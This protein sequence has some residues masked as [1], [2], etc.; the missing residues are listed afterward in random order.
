[1]RW[2]RAM[3]TFSCL[4]NNRC[5]KKPF[6]GERGNHVSLARIRLADTAAYRIVYSSI[7]LVSKPL[8]A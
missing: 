8:F 7:L 5:T 4:T 6:T 2:R 1:M 3:L